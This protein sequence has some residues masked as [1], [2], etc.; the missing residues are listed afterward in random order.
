MTID[1]VLTRGVEQILPSKD[2]LAGLMQ[3]K[4]I[5]L[6]LGIDPTGNE[7][8]LG[9]A[10]PLRKL[11]QFADL[12]HDVILLIGNGTVK[13]GDPTGR[14]KTRPQL[15][16]EEIE[17][18]FQN[19]KAQAS[20]VVNFDQI[21]ITRNGDWLEKLTYVEMIKLCAKFTVQQMMERDMFVERVKKNL[22]VHVH[23]LL[24]PIMQGFDSV[25][26][27][28]DLEIGGNDQTFNMM[29]GRDLQKSEH[30]KE[31]WVLATK[32]ING[33]DGRKMSKSYGNFVS[34]T[35][36]PIDMFGKIMSIADSEIITY[37]EV[38]TNVSQGDITDIKAEIDGGTN[39]MKFKKQ[40]AHLITTW[41]H[42]SA[43]ADSAQEHFE[44]TVQQ[45]ELPENMPAVR[46][47]SMHVTTLT[48]VRAARSD[49]SNSEARRLIE[50]G[51]VEIDGKKHMNP[52]DQVDVKFGSVVKIGKR[53][54]FK[55]EL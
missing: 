24:Y 18:N 20:K 50:Q 7:L 40:L 34:L 2:S 55:V 30:D 42:S 14:D 3:R 38:F 19:W 31:K 9:H 36:K 46:L 16:D 13:I 28:V 1:D 26:M 29:R 12:G 49:M 11:Q 32:L 37:F 54:Y 33:L 5:K 52:V 51:G 53:E 23:E 27:D 25:A 44:K 45:K 21:R 48:I 39:P 35:E 22:P 8:H 47:A 4:K 17:T 10:V 6:Y 43:D 41:L 15:T